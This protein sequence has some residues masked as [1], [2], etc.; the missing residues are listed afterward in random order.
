[1]TA[2]EPQAFALHPR[3]F[4][5]VVYACV[6]LIAIGAFLILP[7]QCLQENGGPWWILLLPSAMI[8]CL[9]S[10]QLPQRFIIQSSSQLECRLFLHQHF[11]G[12]KKLKPAK[13]FVLISLDN[14]KRQV[15]VLC[16]REGSRRFLG[17]DQFSSTEQLHD[18]AHWLSQNTGARLY[19]V[20]RRFA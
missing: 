2:P 4:L 3:R 20:Q 13:A 14:P 18:L 17:D 10:F 8:Y 1:M 16:A 5:R 19:R 15:L 11:F 12:G 6:T 9:I 7:A